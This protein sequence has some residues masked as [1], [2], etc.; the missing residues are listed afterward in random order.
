MSKRDYNK[1]VEKRQKVKRTTLVVG[2][3][4]GAAF[5]A[6]A[7]M[8]KEGEVLGKYPKGTSTRRA[9]VSEDL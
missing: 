3:D 4:I 7:L 6:V 2:V 9:Q 5:N 1:Q 8:N